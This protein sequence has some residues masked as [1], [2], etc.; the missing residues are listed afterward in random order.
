ME[1][2]KDVIMNHKLIL[3]FLLVFNTPV[4]AGISMYENCILN[5]LNVSCTTAQDSDAPKFMR[6]QGEASCFAG[7]RVIEKINFKGPNV[8]KEKINENNLNK[9]DVSNL[10]YKTLKC[11][12]NPDELKKCSLVL[13]HNE[14]IIKIQAC[15]YYTAT[16]LLNLREAEHGIN[17]DFY[18]FQL[19]KKWE[20]ENIKINKDNYGF[21]FKNNNN[22]NLVL[23]ISNRLDEKQYSLSKKKIKSGIPSLFPKNGMELV[24][25]AIVDLGSHKLTDEIIAIHA[26]TKLNL[27][28]YYIY[29]EDRIAILSLGEAF[30]HKSLIKEVRN[31]VGRFKWKTP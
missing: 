2:I 24:K 27:I 20:I 29:G 6:E 7:E 15:K 1:K 12:E 18:K 22:E 25:H 4:N 8:F 28:Q 26:T 3:F 16:P 31:I 9:K 23:T 30:K 19:S 14:S 13:T 17:S 11:V 21:I 10:T 5:L